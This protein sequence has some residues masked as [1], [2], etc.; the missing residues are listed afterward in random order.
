MTDFPSTEI[1]PLFISS[2]SVLAGGEGLRTGTAV[3]GLAAVTSSWQTASL[4]IY[5]PLYIPTP[6]T[7]RRV[8]WGNGSAL[9]G[10]KDFG[11]YSPDGTKI[12]STGST[13]ESGA[14]AIQYVTPTAFVLQTGRYYMAIVCDQTTNHGWGI[15]AGSAI[16]LRMAGYLQQATAL[17]LPNSA[18]FAAKANTFIPICGITQTASGF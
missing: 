15:A 3:P 11:I 10:N 9:A 18:T 5:I 17:P 8:F 16:M 6:Y 4:A 2:L 14:S 7:V 13:A 12:Y 1:S